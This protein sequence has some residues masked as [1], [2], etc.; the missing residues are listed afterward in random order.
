[1]PIKAAK[2]KNRT[3]RKTIKKSKTKK[4]LRRVNI[5]SLLECSNEKYGC[6]LKM[7]KG[8]YH[9][10]KRSKTEKHRNKPDVIHLTNKKK[11]TRKLKKSVLKAVDWFDCSEFK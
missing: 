10:Y 2:R 3:Q 6:D 1:M 8:H 7:D 9:C 4:S 5:S 11:G